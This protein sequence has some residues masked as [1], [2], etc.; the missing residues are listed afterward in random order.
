MYN[1]QFSLSNLGKVTE[2][3]PII[4]VNFY[5]NYIEITPFTGLINVR[6]VSKFGKRRNVSKFQFHLIDNL[7][8]LQS[9]FQKLT[10]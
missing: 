3:E 6:T 9:E 1:L 4:L 8:F 10:H 5:V 2:R 7:F